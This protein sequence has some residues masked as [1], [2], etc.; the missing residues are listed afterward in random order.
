VG[1]SI[2]LYGDQNQDLIYYPPGEYRWI[3]LISDGPLDRL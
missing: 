2:D 1:A 3:D